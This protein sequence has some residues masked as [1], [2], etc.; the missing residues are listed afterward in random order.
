LNEAK[1][2]QGHSSIIPTS[3]SSP[4]QQKKDP[5]NEAVWF[6]IS[7]RIRKND[8]PVLNKKLEMSGFKTFNEFV[9]A[10]IRGEYPKFHNN[11]QVEKLL[12]K[13]REGDIKDPRSGEF[14]PSFF[15]N[16]DRQDMLNDLSKKYI[17]KKHAK[18]L[19]GYFDRYCDIFF[20]NPQLIRSESGHKRAWICDAMRR[21]G[22]YYDRRFNNPQLR[23]LISEIIQRYELNKKMRI[24]DRLWLTDQ[25]YLSKMIHLVLTIPGEIGILI[26]FALYTGLRGEEIAYVHNTQICDRLFGCNCPKLHVVEKKKAYS[27]IVINRIVGQK[28]CYFTI[29]CTKLWFDFR[30]LSNV[31]YEQR[32]VA[33]GLLRSATDG[34]VSFMDL[35][36]FHY[37]VLCRSDLKESGAEVLEGRAKSVSAKHYLLHEIDKMVEQYHDAWE[38]LLSPKS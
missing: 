6:T 17:Y 3:S 7:A 5:L 10:W 31:E 12:I 34:K 2:Q 26:K 38:T 1:K 30:A 28:H 19:V 22:E 16:V 25:D 9:K 15:R 20:T 35:R 29:V 18:D 14:S 21:F 11:E 23:L 36:K 8:L 24:H 13:L 4:K 37:N 33:H 32:K 27:V